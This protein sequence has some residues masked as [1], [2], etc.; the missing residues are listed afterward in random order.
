MVDKFKNYKDF[1][2]NVNVDDVPINKNMSV[3]RQF[4]N[5]EWGQN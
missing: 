4:T 3:Q 5:H 1:K 2:I